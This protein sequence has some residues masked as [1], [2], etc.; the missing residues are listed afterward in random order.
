[1]GAPVYSLTL[2]RHT[3]D[4]ARYSLRLCQELL[5][6]TCTLLIDGT[7]DLQTYGKNN[8]Q[9]NAVSSF[10]VLT[11]PQS[12]LGFGHR[13]PG[14]SCP[15]HLLLSLLALVMV[16]LPLLESLSFEKQG[17]TPLPA[18]LLMLGDFPFSPSPTLNG[19][20]LLKVSGSTWH[21]SGAIRVRLYSC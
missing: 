4:N 15:P 9:L 11:T 3:A 18:S 14:P 12:P 2:R 17:L 13:G 5:K 20:G 10:R 19:R 8:A 6:R 1:M 7:R 21:P 16:F